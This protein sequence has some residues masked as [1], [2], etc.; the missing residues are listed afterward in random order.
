[1]DGPTLEA[2]AQSLQERSALWHQRHALAMPAN[3]LLRRQLILLG[4]RRFAPLC[5]RQAVALWRTSTEAHAPVYR[6]FWQ[7]VEDLLP[8]HKM[9]DPL[10]PAALPAFYRGLEYEDD[11]REDLALQVPS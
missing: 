6:A 1:M 5:V 7:G 2:W 11:G 9:I 4:A 10:Q 8:E 3:R